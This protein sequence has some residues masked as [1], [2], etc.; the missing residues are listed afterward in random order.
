MP[1]YTAIF[2]WPPGEEEYLQDY[3]ENDAE[4]DY[5]LQMVQNCNYVFILITNE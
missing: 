5:V 3:A 2:Y 4:L 1:F